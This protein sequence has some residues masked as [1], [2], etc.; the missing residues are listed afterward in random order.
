[1]RTLDGNGGSATP[2]CCLANLAITQSTEHSSELL[3]HMGR[4]DSGI[5]VFPG[6]C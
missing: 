2:R 6:N 4:E 1:M 3:N 5:L